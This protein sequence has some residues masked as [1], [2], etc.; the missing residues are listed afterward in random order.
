MIG[1]APKGSLAGRL[2]SRTV[3]R[4]YLAA[5]GDIVMD[6]I[7]L[8]GTKSEERQLRCLESFHPASVFRPNDE[9]NRM[10]GLGGGAEVP[11]RRNQHIERSCFWTRIGEYLRLC[12][13][14][15]IVTC[16]G[17]VRISTLMTDEAPGAAINESFVRV[18]IA[19]IA[20]QARHVLLQAGFAAVDEAPAR[21]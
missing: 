20:G 17:V 11:I 6:L 1:H 14:D 16:D 15:G 18:M 8:S 10:I 4:L 2:Y 3:H 9:R 19:G 12:A 21:V 7:A 13:W 5:E